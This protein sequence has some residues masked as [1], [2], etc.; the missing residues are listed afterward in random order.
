MQ[1]KK[2]FLET[3][4]LNELMKFYH[5]V[6]GLPVRMENQ[7]LQIRAGSSDLCFKQH[8]GGQEPCYH[9][10]FNIPYNKIESARL[11]LKEKISL[12][13]MKDYDSEIAEFINWNARSIYFIDPAGNIVELI[14]R[15]EFCL[16]KSNGF[17]SRDILS[18]SEIGI[19]Y[20]KEEYANKV[21]K[22]METMKLEYFSRQKPQP[23]F[24]AIGNDEGLLIAVFQHRSWYPTNI[25]SGIYPLEIEIL[26]QGELFRQII[27]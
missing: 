15:K 26:N 18:I 7:L 22:I 23:G 9:F 12:L 2:I 19:V 1:I 27:S 8:E 13:W 6:A 5:E 20:Q 17:G 11:W 3:T 14:G 25:L 16:D 10:A 4:C 21:S 24:S